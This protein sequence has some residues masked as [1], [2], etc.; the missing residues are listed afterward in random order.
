MK[1]F[2]SAQGETPPQSEENN[3][4][5]QHPE[6]TLDRNDR[7]ALFASRHK[8]DPQERDRWVW[9]S[10]IFTASTGMAMI[11]AAIFATVLEYSGFW[12]NLWVVICIGFT[13]SFFVGLF[14][15]GSELS[16]E[17]WPP[18]ATR[19]GVGR[20]LAGSAHTR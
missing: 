17:S 6:D 12:Q 10:M 4:L 7:D 3:R 2:D 1:T 11:A 5:I 19:H 8:R 13:V 20:R 14:R 18:Q 15:F 16:S 9:R